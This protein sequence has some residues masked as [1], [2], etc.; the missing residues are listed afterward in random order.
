LAYTTAGYLAGAIE[1]RLRRGR[2]SRIA[3]STI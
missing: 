2:P 3:S 1:P